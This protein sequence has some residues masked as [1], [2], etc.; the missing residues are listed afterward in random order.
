MARPNAACPH[1]AS[2]NVW[3]KAASIKF[4]QPRNLVLVR[5]ECECGAKLTRKVTQED[6]EKKMPRHSGSEGQ[7][8]S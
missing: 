7:P 1:C 4:R 6:F 3:I 8:Q 5:Y 2:T